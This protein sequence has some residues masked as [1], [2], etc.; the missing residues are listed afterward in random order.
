MYQGYMGMGFAPM[1][2]S[3]DVDMSREEECVRVEQEQGATDIIDASG[4]EVPTSR[5]QSMYTRQAKPMDLR[6]LRRGA[7]QWTRTL[8]KHPI[9]AKMKEIGCV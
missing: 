3:V 2:C 7:F 5:Y 4:D 8:Y 1:G 9:P 6:N